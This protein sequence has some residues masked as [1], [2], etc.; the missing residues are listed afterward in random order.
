MAISTTGLSVNGVRLHYEE[1][2][3]GDPILCIHGAGSTALVWADAVDKLAPARPRDRL[4][5]A[6]LRPQRAPTALRRTS[7]GEHADDAAAL[8]LGCCKGHRPGPVG[9]QGPSAT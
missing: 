3:S 6:R 5:P 9:Q 1:H 7:I 8:H 2:G 4:R